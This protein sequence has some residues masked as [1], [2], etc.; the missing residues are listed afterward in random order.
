TAHRVHEDHP[1]ASPGTGGG[2]RG[3]VFD[4]GPNV[5]AGRRGLVPRYRGSGPPDPSAMPYLQSL[6]THGVQ[7]GSAVWRG[8]TRGFASIQPAGIAAG[9]HAHLHSGQAGTAGTDRGTGRVV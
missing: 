6:W 5:G 3:T 2:R 8:G 7:R 9:R 4:S 1:V